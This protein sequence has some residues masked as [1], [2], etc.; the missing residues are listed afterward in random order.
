MDLL[1]LV[2]LTLISNLALNPDP[3]NA[4]RFAVRLALR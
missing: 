3:Q 1:G 4:A 2:M